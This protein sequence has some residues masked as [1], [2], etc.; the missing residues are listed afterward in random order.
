[1]GDIYSQDDESDTIS[2]S[3]LFPKQY[4]THPD[5]DDIDILTPNPSG[6]YQTHPDHDDIVIYTSGDVANSTDTHK[7]IGIRELLNDKR[8]DANNNVVGGTMNIKEPKVNSVISNHESDLA[9]Q[10]ISARIANEQGLES[11]Q[12]YL[13]DTFEGKKTI[14]ASTN[15]SVA[16]LDKVTGKV[17]AAQKYYSIYSNPTPAWHGEQTLSW[18]H[19]HWLPRAM[20]QDHLNVHEYPHLNISF[21]HPGG[22][23]RPS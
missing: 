18:L 9:H 23:L 17:T 21:H 8:L 16:V 7:M 6:R 12:R 5:H 4:Q 1:M 20:P 3:R 14:I 15:Y 19:H 10:V 11:A 13:T 2:L 22:I